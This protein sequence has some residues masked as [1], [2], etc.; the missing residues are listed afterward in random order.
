MTEAE[1]AMAEQ[2]GDA[3]GPVSSVDP[4]EI[5][6]HEERVK[7]LEARLQAEIEE[8]NNKYKH[9]LADFQNYQRR[10]IENE[11]EA[12][13]Q[14]LIGVV[15]SLMGVLDNFDLALRQDPA[16]ASAEQ[17][18]QGVSMVK[19]QMMQALASVGVTPI[20]PAPGDE[21]DPRRHEAVAHVPAEGID[22]GR[23]AACFQVGYA[24]ADRV[25]RPAKTSV[26]KAP[27]A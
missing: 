9:A 3:G 15:S 16:K 12:R 1:R 27:D 5:V 6:A 20:E 26:A 19:A 13:R 14:G 21:F 24:L 4:E 8:L 2:C 22:P 23:V 25:L 10:A 18:M 17:I 7:E 11:R